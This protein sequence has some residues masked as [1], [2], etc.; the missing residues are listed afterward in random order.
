MERQRKEAEYL[1]QF[2]ELPPREGPAPESEVLPGNAPSVVIPEE[3]TLSS[4][5]YEDSPA[6][7]GGNAPV[8]EQAPEAVPE[9]DLDAVREELR[10]RAEESGSQ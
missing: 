5:P 9:G 7:D 8:G 2:G 6:T 4:G 1:A 10:R 3:D